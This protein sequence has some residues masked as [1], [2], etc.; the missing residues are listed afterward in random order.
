LRW[1]LLV[2][3]VGRPGHEN[4][5]ADY[6]LLREAGEGVGVLRIYR[7]DPACLS[8]GRN[9]PARRRYN[10]EAIERLGIDVVRRPTGGRAVWHDREVTY[11]VVAPHDTFGSLAATYRSIH[12]ML[13][14]A[15]QTLGLAATLA[16]THR[17]STPPLTAG[18]CFASPVGGEVT[19]GEHK[20][21]GSAQLREGK[22]F[23]QHGSLLLENGQDLI[24]RVTRGTAS[25]TEATSLNQALCRP[26]AF[27]EVA[28]AIA[29]AAAASWHGEW[30]A[31]SLSTSHRAYCS[32][33]D[34]AWTW[35]R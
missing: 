11:S 12:S 4:M 34:S 28:K 8:F 1:H 22:A 19:I 31:N 9:E 13:A 17:R 18:A 14:A 35:R 7:W 16:P 27:D 20:L 10:R 24:T 3:S 32:F 23:L 26:V 5:A 2:D 30:S 25:G 21:I 6:A 29:G 15:L 33:E